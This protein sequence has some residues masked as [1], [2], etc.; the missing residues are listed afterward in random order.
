MILRQVTAGN[1]VDAGNASVDRGDDTHQGAVELWFTDFH[2]QHDHGQRHRGPGDALDQ[3]GEEQHFDAGG[4]G[5][6]HGADGQNHQHAA[7]DLFAA[8]DVTEPGKEQGEESGSGE[9]RRLG[10]GDGRRSGVQLFFNGQQC[11]G[12]HGGVQLERHTGGQ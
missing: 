4:E 9:E 6:H 8:D 12:K 1:G 2:P 5:G 3:P 10:Q 11:G 7:Q